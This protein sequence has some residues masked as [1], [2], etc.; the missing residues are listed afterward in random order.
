MYEC[1]V[2]T[3]NR[4]VCAGDDTQAFVACGGPFRDKVDCA[5]VLAKKGAASANPPGADEAGKDQ[6]KGDEGASQPV[7]PTTSGGGQNSGSTGSG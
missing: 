1:D 3:S 7:V 6:G 4:F 5:K 2:A